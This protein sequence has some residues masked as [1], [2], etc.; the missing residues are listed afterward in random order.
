MRKKSIIRRLIPWILL[1][2]FITVMVVIF[3]KI[4]SG[5]S[6]SFSRET[7]VFYYEGD[8]GKVKMENDDLVYERLGFH[9]RPRL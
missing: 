7:S 3:S 5:E 1:A 9:L 6:R 4:Y 2:A 8:G